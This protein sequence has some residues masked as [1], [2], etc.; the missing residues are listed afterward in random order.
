MELEKRDLWRRY[1]FSVLYHA[2]GRQ[3]EAAATLSELIKNYRDTAAYQIAEVYA[4]RGEVD[5]AFEWLERAY[6]QR[7]SELSQIKGD[8][9]LKRLASDPRYS[10]LLGKMRLPL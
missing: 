7:D 8:P 5:R 6:A 3:K 1:G 4:Y 9:H 2:V 10:A